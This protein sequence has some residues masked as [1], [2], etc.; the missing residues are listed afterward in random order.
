MPIH[1]NRPTKYLPGFAGAPSSVEKSGRT[2]GTRCFLLLRSLPQNNFRKRPWRVVGA[3]ATGW[4]EVGGKKN[5]PVLPVKMTLALR[6]RCLV[7]G[8]GVA[9]CGG[10]GP[11]AW[12]GE[13]ERVGSTPA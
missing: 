12:V 7:W 6:P 13:C 5:A 8:D 10:C 2:L 11:C 3:V 9:C 1:A 4:L